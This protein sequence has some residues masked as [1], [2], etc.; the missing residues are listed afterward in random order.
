MVPSQTTQAAQITVAYSGLYTLTLV[1]QCIQK[2][3]LH[4]K[5]KQQGKVFERYGSL[6][7]RPHDRLSMN[8]LEWMPVFMGP[9]WSLAATDTL[10]ATSVNIA[11]T[12]VALRLLYFALI[13]RFGVNISG[14]NVPLWVST[15]PG[16]GCLTYLLVKAFKSV[17]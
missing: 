1:N 8:Y 15:F 10:D 9:L 2:K 3:L 5:H 13:F 7:M 14:H 12:Y 16:Y 17:F 11:W 4:R 6:D